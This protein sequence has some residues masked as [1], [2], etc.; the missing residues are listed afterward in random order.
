[1]KTHFKWLRHFGMSLFLIAALV[2]SA[3][4]AG[5]LLKNG[6]LAEGMNDLPTDWSVIS[7]VSGEENVSTE[8]GVV[9]LVNNEENDLRLAQL[10]KLR[11]N[12]VY[13][14]SAEI[15]AD[16]VYAGRGATVCIDNFDM[17]GCYLYSGAVLGNA[18]FK[19]VMLSFQTDVGQTM[20]RVELRLGGYSEMS[21]GTA[22]FRNVQLFEGAP[23][24]MTVVALNTSE[25]AAA[26][27]RNADTNDTEAHRI[28]LRSVPHLFLVCT[29]ALAVVLVFGFFRN[30][31]RIGEKPMEKK[32]FRCAM[33][34]AVVIGLALRSALCS[35]WGGH[36]TDMSCWTG[37]GNYI[38]QN[39]TATFYTAIGHDWYDYPPAYM[40]VLGLIARLEMLLHIPV[41]SDTGVFLYMLPA[42]IADVLIALLLVRTARENGFSDRRC[43][44]LALFV[45][46]NPAAVVLSG[47]WG[48]IDSIL[49]LFLLLSFRELLR[50][51][52][53]SAGALFGLAV[54]I[55]WQALIYGPVLAAVYIFSL[56]TFKELRDTLLGILAAFA[57]IFVCS[58]P[59]KGTQDA[60]WI[61]GRFLHSA[62]GY[63]YASVEAYNFLSLLGGN[64]TATGKGM[65]GGLTYRTFGLI[66]IVLAVML[67]IWFSYRDSRRRDLAAS[68]LYLTAS[69]TMF[70]IFTFGFY[71]HER[72][73]FPVIFLL[74]FAYLREKDP[75][76]LLF[77]MLLSCVAC[78]NECNAMFVVSDLAAA[79]VRGSSE[80]N[81][82]VTICSLA[83][84]IL[85]LWFAAEFA[86]SRIEGG[87]KKCA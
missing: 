18:D 76:W 58:L 64:W 10:V 29:I 79:V 25:H 86:I 9:T 2:F 52:R 45:I 44:L 66:A 28:F 43:F 46:F 77:S 20:C 6:E 23:E 24:G 21:R 30:R 65:I 17:D 15:A 13:T 59:F 69:F 42:Y 54:M 47:A 26:A 72:Y 55:K 32:E 75:K 70:M 31:E 67:G 34:C 53:I 62:G 37:W 60:L 3:S 16:G 78:L 14:L 57:V 50:D 8:N 48:Q 22:R 71:M 87:D 85:F 82:L 74:L 39:G 38:A 68:G 61:V 5:E 40:L 83:E 4:A 80:H 19:P 56:R 81:S 41:G 84:S 11:E 12:T 51:R 27:P 49:T 33:I 63:D 1:M 7:Y 36:D 73:V 35:L